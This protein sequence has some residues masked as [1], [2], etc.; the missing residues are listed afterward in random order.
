MPR[1]T[2]KLE[3]MESAY[4]FAP[5]EI[6]V[7]DTK[8]LVSKMMIRRRLTRASKIA[9]YLSSEVNFSKGRIVYGSSFGELPSTASILDAISDKE[10]ISP[11][12]FQNSV[13]NTAISY[14][15]ILNE[16]EEE[17]LT[18]SSGDKTALNVL[19]AGA[20][21]ALDGDTLLL[22]L[23]ETLNIE[24]IEKVNTCEQYLECGVALK[25]RLS[26]AEPTLQ[27]CENKDD[28]KV[29]SSIRLMLNIAKQC[30]VGK[31]NI[32]EVKL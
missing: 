29:P 16:N 18:I 13:Y 19:K 7:L 12:H 10:S 6:E 5:S 31:T 32:V 28:K 14:L 9:I 30:H 1:D 23:T 22:L 20:I 26:H 24:G 3:I 21:K 8:K 25:V 27:Y 11:T 15:S 17:L 2:I 4:V